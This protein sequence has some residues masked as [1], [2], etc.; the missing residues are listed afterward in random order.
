MSYNV[1]LEDRIDHFFIKN[2]L[3]TKN[4]Q[5]GGVGWLINGNISVGIFEDELVCRVNPDLINK[6]MQSPHITLFTHQ[7]GERDSFL[8]ISEMLYNSD[9]A[10]HKF[11]NH[12]A[13]FT[14]ILPP[15]G[16]SKK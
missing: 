16:M 9:K 6:L 3:I 11:L 13:N 10:L 7:K 5:M 15:K 2:E 12:S 8:S 14:A 4:K 1:K